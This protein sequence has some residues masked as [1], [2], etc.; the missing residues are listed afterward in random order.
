M[1]K[2]LLLVGLVIYI[3]VVAAAIAVSISTSAKDDNDIIL[4]PDGEFVSAYAKDITFYNS[5]AKNCWFR[6][7]GAEWI[8]SNGTILFKRISDIEINTPRDLKGTVW[9]CTKKGWNPLGGEIEYYKDRGYCY[10]TSLKYGKAEISAAKLIPG[11]EYV[12]II[13]LIDTSNLF[14]YEDNPGRDHWIKIDDTGTFDRVEVFGYGP[15]S[16]VG[17]KIVVE[18]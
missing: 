4:S 6:I 9:I 12:L 3:G 18:E 5:S 1:R 14:R 15:I 10:I 17:F 13:E 8:Y 2:S 16:K 11:E 7:S